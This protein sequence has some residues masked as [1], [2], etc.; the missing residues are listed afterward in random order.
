MLPTR[1]DASE[2]EGRHW[3]GYQTVIVDV[4]SL[5][6]A[7]GGLAFVPKIEGDSGAS[8]GAPVVVLMGLGIMGYVFGGPIVHWTHERLGKGFLSLGFRIA[9]PLAGLGVGALI[10]TL[11]GPGDNLAG[12]L[13]GASAGAGLAMVLD[14]TLLGFERAPK[15]TASRWQL[16]P[17]I[18]TPT[19]KTPIFGL[20]GAW[21]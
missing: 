9:G 1:A 10:P 18:S 4:A 7:A 20:R 13:I 12:S 14:A 21:R 5:V 11:V 6:S 16:A 8:E 3:I 17:M 19:A 15:K 2:D